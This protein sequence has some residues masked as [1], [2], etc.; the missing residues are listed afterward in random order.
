MCPFFYLVT[1]LHT[2]LYILFFTILLSEP[3]KPSGDKDSFCLM[4]LL[5][6]Q[7]K[8]N[9]CSYTSTYI[10]IH[11]LK[12][13]CLALLLFSFWYIDKLCIIEP[14]HNYLNHIKIQFYNS[15]LPYYECTVWSIKDKLL[16]STNNI[17]NIH[18]HILMYIHNK[19]SAIHVA[20]YNMS[21][22]LLY[23][24][25]IIQCTYWK[26][27]LLFRSPLFTSI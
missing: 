3:N 7:S 22:F 23:T 19:S 4:S 8:I 14:N 17:L 1:H 20:F 16:C 11:T 27:K 2:V 25:L 10:C 13:N 26:N 12:W 15:K 24:F 21:F 5:I 9:Y 18:T 6:K